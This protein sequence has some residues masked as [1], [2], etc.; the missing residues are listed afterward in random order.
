MYKKSVPFSKFESGLLTRTVCPRRFSFSQ[1]NVLMS[2]PNCEKDNL[3]GQTVLVKRPIS[4][5]EKGTLFFV[6]PLYHQKLL[7]TT[8]V[9]IRDQ[10]QSQYPSLFSR[11]HIIPYYVVRLYTIPLKLVALYTPFLKLR[12]CFK[13]P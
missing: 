1:F 3:L 5:F 7:L 13:R 12:N 8:S 4:N 9:L 2:T 6:H 11:N 10:I